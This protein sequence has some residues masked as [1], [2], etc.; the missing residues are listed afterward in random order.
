MLT[1]VEPE[2]PHALVLEEYDASTEPGKIYRLRRADEVDNGAATDPTTRTF[3]LMAPS[4]IRPVASYHLAVSD[5]TAAAGLAHEPIPNL[6]QTGLLIMD[7][8]TGTWTR[9]S[10]NYHLG[11]QREFLLFIHGTF[12]NSVD[13]FKD[14]RWSDIGNQFPK[15][16]ILG[17]NHD[18]V[19]VGVEL[20]ATDILTMLKAVVGTT[21]ANIR[22]VCHSR[23]GLV[24]RRLITSL[25]TDLRNLNVDR[26]VTYGSTHQGTSLA[27]K[28]INVVN[29]ALNW[30]LK[31]AHTPP[32]LSDAISHIITELLEDRLVPGLAD[33]AHNSNFITSLI[34]RE[35]GASR[36]DEEFYFGSKFVAKGFWQEVGA[37][38]L[39]AGVFQKSNDTVVDT[40]YTAPQGVNPSRINSTLTNCHTEYFSARGKAI[41]DDLS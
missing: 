13:A 36:A 2:Q 28:A 39:D 1:E 3:S 37:L 26:F 8:A 33:Q 15:F 23:G 31:I 16:P 6:K 29:M 32:G 11:V 34:A 18:T 22:I 14:V 12:S 35:G 30:L 38:A 21:Q 27:N 24:G 20:N 9:A 4:E 40:E 7:P 17:Y 25:Q 19:T 41:A 5:P 10:A